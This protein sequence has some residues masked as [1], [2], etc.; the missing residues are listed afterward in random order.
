MNDAPENDRHAVGGTAAVDTDDNGLVNG[1]DNRTMD[2]GLVGEGQREQNVMNT[3]RDDPLGD[4]EGSYSVDERALNNEGLE[5]AGAGRNTLDDD[6]L[7]GKMKM[8]LSGEE[9]LQLRE[10]R[11]NVDKEKVRTGEVRIDKHVETDH[12]EFDVPVRRE[13]VTI[14]RRPVDGKQRSRL[15]R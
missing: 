3:H 9:K 4:R 6:G 14:E 13:E 2:D 8:S 5:S 1:R 7:A 15:I 10:E 11:L 12:Q